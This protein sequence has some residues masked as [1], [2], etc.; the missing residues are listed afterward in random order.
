MAPND[1][2]IEHFCHIPL[3]KEFKGSTVYEAEI[4]GFLLFSL[5]ILKESGPKHEKIEHFLHIFVTL[6]QLA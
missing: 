3:A 6:A 1:E 2:K 5:T 4:K